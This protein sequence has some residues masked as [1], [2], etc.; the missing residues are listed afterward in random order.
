[1]AIVAAELTHWRLEGLTWESDSISML[2][3]SPT[4]KTLFLNVTPLIVNDL[5]NTGI[6]EF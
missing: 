3:G 5:N 6:L 4:K 2:K 1:V